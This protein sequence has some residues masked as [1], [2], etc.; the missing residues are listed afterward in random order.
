MLDRPEYPVELTNPD[1]PDLFYAQSFVTLDASQDSAL[2]AGELVPCPG[3]EREL[4]F[5]SKDGKSVL[6]WIDLIY[7]QDNQRGNESS[8]HL[9]EDDFQ[10]EA[11]ERLTVTNSHSINQV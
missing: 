1:H 6:I 3:C 4:G 9:K 2:K 5:V 7:F 8:P 10:V 11:L